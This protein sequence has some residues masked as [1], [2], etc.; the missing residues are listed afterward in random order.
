LINH[1]VYY[2]I[3]KIYSKHFKLYTMDLQNY[4]KL[5]KALTQ[6]LREVSTSKEAARRCIDEMGIRDIL[7]PINSSAKKKN[8]KNIARKNDAK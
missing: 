8:S 7:V 4:L 2:L 6:E 3:L 1:F 5:K